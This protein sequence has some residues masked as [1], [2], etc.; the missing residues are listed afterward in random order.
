MKYKTKILAER[1]VSLL[2]Q[3]PQVECVCLNEAADSD[4]LDPYFAL[5]LDVYHS[6]DIP[7]PKERREIYGN[8]AAA[9]ETS[10][11]GHKDRF[12]VGNL[13]VRLEYKSTR[14]I[15]E[16]VA[17][18]DENRK[19]LWLIKDSGTYGYYRLAQGEVL[20]SRSS[21]IEG[22][23]GRLLGLDDDF[24]T[25]ARDANQ[26][27][28]EHYLSDLGAA[29]IHDDQFHYLISSAMFIKS[30]CLVLFCIN[31]RFEPSHRGYYK[32]VLELSVL[33]ESFK[34]QIETFVR[35]KS[36]LNMERKFSLAKL[37]A[38]NIIALPI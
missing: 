32:K 37:I 2:S 10:S 6:D 4:T 35:E 36:D 3:W 15:E 27:K 9:L 18:A 22:I 28:M 34:A 26:S 21:W 25:Q 38:K 31:R 17:I 23:R 16:L 1:F 11:R 13:P 20:F 14:Q 12:L 29:L 30:A 33:P 7:T 19:H 24:W 5:I 8:D